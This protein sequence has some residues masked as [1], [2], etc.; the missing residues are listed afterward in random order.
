MLLALVIVAAIAPD[1]AAA[2]IYKYSDSQGRI[3][4]SYKHCAGAAASSECARN[5]SSN[6]SQ[7]AASAARDAK[8]EEVRGFYYVEIP[9]L[10]REATELMASPDRS[11]SGNGWKAQQGREAFKDLERAWERSAETQRRYDNAL[12]QLD[13]Y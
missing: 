2:Q 6:P 7:Q 13:G 4:F 10:E 11:G 12:H 8:W 3:T 1:H 5:T 9:Q